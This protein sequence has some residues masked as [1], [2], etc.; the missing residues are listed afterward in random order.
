M[1]GTGCLPVYTQ[2]SHSSR[3]VTLPWGG[4][5]PD[6]ALWMVAL[7]QDCGQG[8]DQGT[9]PCVWLYHWVF[10]EEK[11]SEQSQASLSFSAPDLLD[12]CGILGTLGS[13]RTL[14]IQFSKQTALEIK[15]VVL[16]RRKLCRYV[17]KNK[18]I[19]LTHRLK[20][21][22]ITFC[23]FFFLPLCCK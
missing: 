18:F 10:R 4:A 17:L 7:V 6:S 12:W 16:Q 3:S 1:L 15:Y 5:T 14:N 23:I 13:L 11:K 2:G 20:S 22:C 21:C 8:Q 19:L 9:Q